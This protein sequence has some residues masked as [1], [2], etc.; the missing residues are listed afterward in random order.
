MSL[1]RLD[2]IAP[3][4]ARAHRAE[5]AYQRRLAEQRRRGW[6]SPDVALIEMD[7]NLRLFIRTATRSLNDVLRDLRG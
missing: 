3:R 2:E 6:L 7:R 1:S 4:L 5:M